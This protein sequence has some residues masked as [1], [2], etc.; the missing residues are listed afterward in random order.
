MTKA[1]P[2]IG[3][4][5]LVILCVSASTFAV[6]LGDLT[7]LSLKDPNEQSKPSEDMPINSEEEEEFD[8]SQP[9]TL[10]QCIEIA[11]ERASEI[12]TGQLDLILEDMN[13][14]EARS[15][16][17][18]QI[19]AT[20]G[21]QFSDAVDF[22]WEKG[23]YSA[24][25]AASY[26][27]WNHG[28]REGA[29]AQARSRRDIGY[30][31][32]N[33]TGQN[34][35]FSVIRSYYSVLEAEKLISV[36]EQVLE[37]SRQNVEKIKTF[38][39]LGVAIP[40]DMATARV[41]QASDE[42]AV[43]NDRNNLELAKAD[44]AV[45]MGLSPN[46]PISVVDA[47]DYEKYMR[48]GI[49]EMEEISIEDSISQ[50]LAH[51]PEMAQSRSNLSILET[52]SM[53]ARLNAW[54]RITADCGYNLMLDDYLREKNALKNHKSWD[55]SARV[56]YPIFD[57]GR[58]RRTVQKAD[59]ALEKMNENISELRR[60]IALDV[61]QTY[62]S[63]ERARK[64]LDITSVQVEDAK[65]SLDVAQGRYE[66]QMIILLELLDSQS[67]YTRALINQVNAFYDYKIAKST[68]DKAMGVLE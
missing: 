35:I 26:T 25:V 42:L 51:R 14:S 56:S 4:I 67:R 6:S 59:I 17:L 9:I 20:G 36:N 40:A 5:V 7:F 8:F 33:Q 61:H 62:L 28:Q 22:G 21:Y 65:M 38:L 34:L 2:Y 66:Q 41:Q 50:A 1:A 23:N 11:Q 58:T 32:F 13:V 52:A 19:D 39:E 46:T 10:E 48:T 68:L 24:S 27:I 64:S 55:V 37:Q 18:P 47:P 57:G 53:L 43:I 49:I 30:S 15:S 12:R 44:L 3:V 29:L 45:S 60:S 31:Q 16:Y 54:P 63:L